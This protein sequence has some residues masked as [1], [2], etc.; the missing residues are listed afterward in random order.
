[1]SPGTRL[2]RYGGEKL[3]KLTTQAEET[4]SQPTSHENHPIILAILSTRHWAV[5]L[6][7]NAKV[8]LPLAPG[9]VWTVIV[10]VRNHVGEAEI[11]H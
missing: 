2:Q 1:M 10:S 5:L 9:Q 6:L 7:R 11:S 4:D 3:W 8:G